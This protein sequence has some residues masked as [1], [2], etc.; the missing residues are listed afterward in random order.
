VIPFAMSFMHFFKGATV[1][2]TGASAGLGEEYAR[3]LAP[4]AKRLLLVARRVDRL[5]ALKKEFEARHSGLEV[6]VLSADLGDPVARESFCAGLDGVVVDLLINNAGLGDHGPFETAQADRLRQM[7]EVNIVA[8][9]ALTHRILPG[10]RKNG[11]GAI[12]NVSSVA[13]ILPVP[14]L[15]VY[16]ATKAYVNSFTESLRA[17]LRGSGIT[18]TAVCP[19]PVETEFTTVARRPGESELPAPNWIKVTPQEVVW[20]SLQAVSR[21]RARVYPGLLVTLAA[22]VISL[23]PIF[24]MR[25]ILASYGKRKG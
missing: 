23:V 20:E 18:V 22:V 6:K 2:I 7:L 12:L 21:D 10:M 11:S 17:E 19:G 9:T 25:V 8:L 15:G 16:S 24:I 1:L 14:G 5:E 13:G 3:Q 4:F